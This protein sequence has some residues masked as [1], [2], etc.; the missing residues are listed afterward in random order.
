M[1]SEAQPFGFGRRSRRLISRSMASRINSARRFFPAISSMRSAVPSGTRTRIGFT[2][3]GGRPMRPVV[4]DIGKFVNSFSKAIS[5]IDVVSDI[6]YKGNIETR[7]DEMGKEWFLYVKGYPEFRVGACTAS[8]ALKAKREFKKLY[9]LK[10]M[11]S[12]ALLTQQ[13]RVEK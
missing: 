10:I 1:T 5:L 4:A 6:A 2:F 7:R 12:G 13:R 8:Q 9:G 11:P 3:I